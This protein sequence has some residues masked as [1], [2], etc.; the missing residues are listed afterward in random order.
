[1][2]KMRISVLALV[3]ASFG[4]AAVWADDIESAQKAIIAA[5]KKTKS[6]S[7]K[8][9]SKMNMDNP[10]FK[11]SQE[12]QGTME[13]RRKGEQFQMRMDSTSSTTTDTGGNVT[14][15][16]STVLMI[17]D[18]EFLYTYSVADGRKSATKSKSTGAWDQDPF[19]TW[20]KE[21]DL[22]LLADESVDGAACYVIEATPKPG[23]G[24]AAAGTSGKMTFHYRKDCGLSVKM[25]THDKDGKVTMTAISTDVKVNP[26]LSDDRFVWKAPAGVEL[27]DMTAMQQDTQHASDQQ[28]NAEADKKADAEKKAEKKPEKK[29]EKKAEKKAEKKPEKKKGLG[30]PKIPKWKKRP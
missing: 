9:T 13:Y 23:S 8:T 5:M 11:F 6:L 26:S 1:M 24:T 10:G 7:A 16:K 15:S 19:E 29:E 21:W 22:K 28:A 14:K 30:L 2:K 12:S 20:K 25:V 4:V 27:M 18:G 17:D 3:A